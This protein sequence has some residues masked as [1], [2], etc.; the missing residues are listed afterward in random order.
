MMQTSWTAPP[1]FPLL[2]HFCTPLPGS[3]PVLLI[4]LTVHVC[5]RLGSW[6]IKRIEWM[7]LTRNI[8]FLQ[9]WSLG[10]PRSR[11]QWIQ[12]PI[13]SPL[14]ALQKAVFW[15]PPPRW[16]ELRALLLSKGTNSFKTA[17][18]FLPNLNP[19]TIKGPPNTITLMLIEASTAE[20]VCVGGRGYR[21]WGSS[22]GADIQSTTMSKTHQCFKPQRFPCFLNYK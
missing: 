5:L 20:C 13:G 9:F 3:C 18:P 2:S 16:R 17:S 22:G 7:A 11:C 6:N 4:F 19:I 14:S 1:V 21:R 15:L 12:L 8:Y 10:S